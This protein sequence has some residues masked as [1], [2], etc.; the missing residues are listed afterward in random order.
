MK[1]P[2]NAQKI[3]VE[4][5]TVDFF[6][7]E[8]DNIKYYYFDTSSCAVPEPMINAMAGLKLINDSKNKLIMLNHQIPAGLF[9]RIENS[10]D[11]EIKRL[12]EQNNV[13]ITFSYKQDSLAEVDFNNNQ[14]LG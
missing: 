5:S 9:P 7:Y 4:N 12:E 10:F 1:I 6:V 14:C 8:Q 11:F 3:K 2:N 13:L